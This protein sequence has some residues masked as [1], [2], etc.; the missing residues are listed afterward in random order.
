[1]CLSIR[2]E[3][4]NNVP[5]VC[6]ITIVCFFFFLDEIKEKKD[7]KEIFPQQGKDLI[8]EK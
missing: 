4:Y 5:V 3:K 1:M 2:F 8:K 7:Y 6:F